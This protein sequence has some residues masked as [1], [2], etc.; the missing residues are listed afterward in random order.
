VNAAKLPD[1]SLAQLFPR[2]YRH[3][4]RPNC[5][6]RQFCATSQLGG[7][8][9]KNARIYNS[10][11][12]SVWSR[13]PARAAEMGLAGLCWP[14]LRRDNCSAFS[15]HSPLNSCQQTYADAALIGTYNAAGFSLV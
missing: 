4:F 12:W 5:K 1:I 7:K 10:P 2:V 8:W 3:S 9:R 15:S 11:W 6:N 13:W 14:E